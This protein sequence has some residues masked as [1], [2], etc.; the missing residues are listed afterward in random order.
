MYSYRDEQKKIDVKKWNESAE[1]GEDKCGTYSF[2][3]LCQREQEYPCAK[4]KRRESNRK[5]KVRVAVAKAR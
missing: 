5:G 3:A 2:C 4:A 1:S